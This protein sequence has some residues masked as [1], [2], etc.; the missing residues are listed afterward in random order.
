MQQSPPTENYRLLNVICRVF[1]KC[2]YIPFVSP[3]DAQR[4]FETC[5][6]LK[7]NNNFKK[8]VFY[9]EQMSCL[10]WTTEQL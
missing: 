4:K 10:L 3:H 7:A 2:V 5:Y 8:E 9:K 6:F 1:F